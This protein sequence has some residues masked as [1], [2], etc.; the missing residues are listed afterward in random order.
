MATTLSNAQGG[1]TTACRQRHL[2]HASLMLVELGRYAERRVL[3][4]AVRWHSEQ[5]VL[6]E[7]SIVF[8]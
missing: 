4:R 3:A 1:P 5:R 2:T 8:V 6:T 7:G